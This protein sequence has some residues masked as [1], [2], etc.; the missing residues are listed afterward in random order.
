M[1]VLYSEIEI[2][3]S[4]EQVW[5]LLTDFDN[6]PKMNQAQ[7]IRSEALAHLLRRARNG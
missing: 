6:F 4:A 1:K 3:A 7:K 5:K 2:Q